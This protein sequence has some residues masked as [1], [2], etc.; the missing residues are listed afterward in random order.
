[1]EP[2]IGIDIGVPHPA[3]RIRSGPGTATRPLIVAVIAIVAI[4]AVVGMALIISS[5]GGDGSEGPGPGGATGGEATEEPTQATQGSGLDV[6]PGI[7]PSVVGEP[8]DVARLAIE[9]A[10]FR[11][12]EQFDVNAD[13][14]RG[15]VYDQA[16]AAGSEQEPGR[17]VFI[18]VSEGPE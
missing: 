13:V 3:R 2:V 6:T 5:L 15:V 4:A 16:P 18:A 14:P 10:G 7:I 9:E 12:T 11:V 17:E 1:M 8:V